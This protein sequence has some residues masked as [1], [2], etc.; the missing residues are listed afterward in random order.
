MS[1]CRSFTA[2]GGPGPGTAATR[3]CAKCVTEE[4]RPTQTLRAEAV[5]L[6]WEPGRSR[7]ARVRAEPQAA[8]RAKAARRWTRGCS[9]PVRTAP[10]SLS[11]F[12]DEVGHRRVFLLKVTQLA[13]SGE[14][15]LARVALRYHQQKV[16]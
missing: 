6:G 7:P 8:G 4:P 16:A 13:Q 10:L 1:T 12:I 3:A 9:Q 5:T 14:T 11:H 15:I 2:R